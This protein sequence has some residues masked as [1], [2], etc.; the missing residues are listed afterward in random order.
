MKT[1]HDA[2]MEVL[3][4]DPAKTY[5]TSELIR[6]IWPECEAGGEYFENRRTAI[7]YTLRSA[8]RYGLV[9]RVRH[10]GR[11]GGGGRLPDLWRAV[12]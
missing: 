1:H 7:N 4:R 3:R 10:I 9:E 11:G 8:M 2:V 6:E 12:E 5:T